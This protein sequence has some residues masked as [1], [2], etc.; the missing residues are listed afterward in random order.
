MLYA[1]VMKELEMR[2]K[3]SDCRKW[4]PTAEL[5]DQNNL[6]QAVMECLLNND[7]EGVMEMLRIHFEAIERSK[8]VKEADMPRS[9]FYHSLKNKN[10][11]IKTLAKLMHAAA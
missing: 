9:T 6:A 5:L 11:T 10:P 1:S 8:I 4:D 3:L 2:T 7:P